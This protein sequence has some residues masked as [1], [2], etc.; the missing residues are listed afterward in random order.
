[1]MYLVY[2]VLGQQMKLTIFNGQPLIK[3]MKGFSLFLLIVITCTSYSFAQ[4]TIIL[5]SKKRIEGKVVE[6]GTSEVTY[7][8]AENFTGPNYRIPKAD[9]FLIIYENG[10]EDSFEDEVN[11]ETKST[12][13]A[14]N[15]YSDMLVPTNTYKLGLEDKGKLRKNDIS[16]YNDYTAARTTKTIFAGIG[17]VSSAVVI[18]SVV[19]G[20]ANF[21][22][23][24][25]A[26]QPLVSREVLI[27]GGVGILAGLLERG[28]KKRIRSSLL[29][30]NE[31]VK[32]KM[33]STS[34]LKFGSTPS[35]VGLSYNF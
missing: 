8:K 17:L 15:D 14:P 30:H 23:N 16:I 3:L 18:Y 22:E 34:Q 26:A 35:G 21:D 28:P 19:R 13:V 7:K 24:D 9:I 11:E 2:Q 6:V 29:R 33:E 27:V 10:T 31:S 1:M 4:D 25:T 5:K 32:Q 12:P 20:L